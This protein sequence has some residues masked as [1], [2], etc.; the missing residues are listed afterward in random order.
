MVQIYS[1]QYSYWYGVFV[2][3]TNIILMILSFSSSPTND[4][5]IKM[6][7]YSSPLNNYI[8]KI[9]LGSSLANDHIDSDSIKF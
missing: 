7:F 3:F 1:Y 4:D 9:S 5:N 8:V 6:S 2:C